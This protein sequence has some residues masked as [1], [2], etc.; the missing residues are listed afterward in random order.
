MQFSFLSR[1]PKLSKKKTILLVLGIV[2]VL[3]VAKLVLGL[4]NLQNNAQ[5]LVTTATLTKQ[6]IEE[7]LSLKAPLEGSESVEVVSRQHYEVLELMVSEGDRVVKDQLLAV[8]DS[9]NLASLVEKAQ[10]TLD[11]AIYQ[12]KEQLEQLQ[13]Q[14]EEATL[15][16]EQ[17]KRQYESTKALYEQG[18]ESREA[19][20]AAQDKLASQK[21]TVDSFEVVS[22]KVV[23]TSSQTKQ[24]E[25]YRKDLAEAQD[26]FA[27][28][29]V[30]SPIDGIVTRV[31]IKVGRFADD[32]EDSKPM[33]VIEDLD[34]LQMKV[35]VSEYDIGKIAVGQKAV[36]TADILKGDAVEAV[37]SRISPTG[38]PKTMGGN[39]RVIPTQINITQ[40]NEN[41]IA[42]ITAKAKIIIDQAEDVLVV[43]IDA[44]MQNED[45]SSQVYKLKTDQTLQ[46]VP[47]TLGLEN[48][49]L[50]AVQGAELAEGDKVV[51]SP[52]AE[53]TEGMKVV[54]MNGQQ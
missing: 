16:L 27:E 33:F 41:L 46:I 36:V 19:W 54:E 10:D 1:L 15:S 51:L 24:I 14:Y 28:S 23:G 17:V 35:L 13:R 38:E 39:E 40:N 42:G 32:T 50:I 2:V 49:L 20:E 30:K 4:N 45:G 7:S 25:I 34:Q 48:D 8:L 21:R 5:S 53:L 31:N 29:Q 47:V 37:V 22:G 9:K 43:P 52:T 44:I 6:D 12:Q 26:N 18:A 3:L 11:L